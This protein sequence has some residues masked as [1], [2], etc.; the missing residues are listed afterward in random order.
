MSPE[1]APC[2]VRLNA[3]TFPMIAEER[4]VL[5]GL[6]HRL[7]EVEGAT[8]DEALAACRDSDAAAA[9]P[10]PWLTSFRASGRSIRLTPM[11]NPGFPSSGSPH[12][13]SGPPS[14]CALPRQVIQ[15]PRV[16]GIPLDPLVRW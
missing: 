9:V 15:G 14:A 3:H 8:D 12:C 4:Q 2:I 13:E 5:A 10:R 7:V 6:P 16:C 11:S 1:A